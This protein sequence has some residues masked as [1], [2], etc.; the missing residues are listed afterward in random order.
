MTSDARIDRLE[1]RVDAVLQRL[2]NV[3]GQVQ[4]MGER[5]T[6]VENRLN[7]LTIVV[8]GNIATTILTAVGIIAAVLI[9]R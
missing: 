9:T 1:Q 7:T 4:Q 8:F 5:L 6:G 3:E 2:S